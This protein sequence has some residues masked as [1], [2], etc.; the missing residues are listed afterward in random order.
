M[1]KALASLVGPIQV[2]PGCL[3]CRLFETWPARD[4]LQME[5]RWDSEEDLVRHLRSDIYKKL[6]LLIEL[7]SAPPVLEFLT[8]LEFRGLD[9]VEA[10]RTS[11]E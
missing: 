8:V 9:L 10:A 11:S 3:S 1:G 5:A 4:G 2:Q 6:L 7:G